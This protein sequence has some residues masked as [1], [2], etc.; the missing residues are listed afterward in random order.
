MCW[1]RGAKAHSASGALACGASLLTVNH[2]AQYM[3]HGLANPAR[4]KAYKPLVPSRFSNT[5]LTLWLARDGST[6]IDSTEPAN[7]PIS[8][9]TSTKPTARSHKIVM[10]G[11]P[12][13]ARMGMPTYK[14]ETMPMANR[15]LQDISTSLWLT[16][17]GLTTLFTNTAA[18]V[19]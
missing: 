1:I 2:P 4:R 14:Q 7:I 17:R 19:Y 3:C 15:Y 10:L 18:N 8:A 13:P 16:G 12:Q 6:M 11:A 9:A 5:P